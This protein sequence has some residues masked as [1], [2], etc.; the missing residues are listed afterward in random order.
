MHS[1][2]LKVLIFSLLIGCTANLSAQLRQVHEIGI[3]GG[4]ATYFGDINTAPLQHLS[5]TRE[6]A[7]IFYRY[8]WHSRWSWKN[9]ISY[10]HIQGADSLSNH[11]FQQRRN[12]SFR[13]RV[14]GYSTVIEF[15]FLKRNKK[16]YQ[17][18]Q[19]F[20]PYIYAGL[21]LSYH[22]PQASFNGEWVDLMPLGTEGQQSALTGND[23]YKHLVLD[24]PIGGGI[25]YLM[26]KHWAIGLEVSFHK[27][28]TDY[29]DDVSKVYID[30][31]ILRQGENGNLAVQLADRS[32]EI[33]VVALGETGTQRG[34]SSR[35]DAYLYFGFSISY[36]FAEMICPS[37][38]GGGF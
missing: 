6:A 15:N 24:L 18:L 17:D 36:L 19:H 20:T 9:S 4:G 26:S 5:T 1:T 31:D 12:L 33:D 13:N 8:N 23:P 16:R 34:D 27:T 21:G 14:Y 29:L 10:A 38:S 3:M 2:K 25:K 35:N 22:N 28:F 30:P 7:A 32:T 37:P 11:L